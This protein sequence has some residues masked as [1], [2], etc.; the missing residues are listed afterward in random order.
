MHEAHVIVCYRFIHFPLPS[1]RNAVTQIAFVLAVVINR[2]MQNIKTDYCQH[3]A[4][5]KT[6]IVKFHC[7]SVDN[8]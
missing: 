5:G 7:P 4:L 3:P 8:F 2:R 6:K 1:M